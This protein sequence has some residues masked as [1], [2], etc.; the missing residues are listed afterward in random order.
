MRRGSKQE[1]EKAVELKRSGKTIDEIASILGRRKST[2]FY[3]LRGFGFNRIT[4]SESLERARKVAVVVLVEKYRKIRD[5]C[6]R[7]GYDNAE[8]I[9]SN[10]GVR[11]FIVMYLAEGYKKS[12]N[13]IDFT[14]TDPSIMKLFAKY[15][16]LFSVKNPRYVLIGHSV[17]EE[18]KKYWAD[19]MKIKVDDIHSYEKGGNVSPRRSNYG[20]FKMVITDTKALQK[21]K[22]LYDFLRAEWDKT[23][24]PVA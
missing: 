21:I 17:T 18:M 4:R 2:V 24:A 16:T 1:K 7:E 10:K 3:W 9:L 23:C 5:G 13:T 12:K 20:T 22:G 15:I 8:E 6:Y 14:N 19:Q 11:D